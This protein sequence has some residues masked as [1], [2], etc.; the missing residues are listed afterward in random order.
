MAFKD[1][2]WKA[3][4]SAG[5]TTDI[6]WKRALLNAVHAGRAESVNT[7]DQDRETD[8]WI[9]AWIL[10]L[11][12]VLFPS[13]ILRLRPTS[14]L[15]KW[16]RFGSVMEVDLQGHA[17]KIWHITVPGGLS[18]VRG[19]ISRGATANSGGKLSRTMS[20]SGGRWCPWSVLKIHREGRKQVLSSSRYQKATNF[21][22]PVNENLN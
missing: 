3:K 8:N 20:A 12:T 14:S 22:S 2:H 21:T 9:L 1:V 18:C 13:P 5:P 11:F 7:R 19:F 16:P 4:R 17:L 15:T 10:L 6:P